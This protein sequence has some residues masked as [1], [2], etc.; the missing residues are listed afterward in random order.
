MNLREHNVWELSQTQNDEYNFCEYIFYIWNTNASDSLNVLLW[1]KE[2][3]QTLPTQVSFQFSTNLAGIIM[4][5]RQR[6]DC[7]ISI[8]AWSVDKLLTGLLTRSPVHSLPLFGTTD[9]PLPYLEQ[10]SATHEAWASNI[11]S[12][13][14]QSLHRKIEY[15]IALHSLSGFYLC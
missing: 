5:D 6:W 7:Q 4:T 2:C 13:L 3:S 1:L 8:R 14:K 15:R 12:T 11:N 10:V 9:D